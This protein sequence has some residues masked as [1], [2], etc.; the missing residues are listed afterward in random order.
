MTKQVWTCVFATLLLAGAVAIWAVNS[1]A[2]P[3]RS[4][5]AHPAIVAVDGTVSVTAEG[6]LFHAA[7]CK[8]LHQPAQAMPASEAVAEGYAPCTRC[9]RK[10]LGK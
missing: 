8:D 9:M 7:S 4:Q 2:Q 3:L 6:N 1:G 5:H 10:A